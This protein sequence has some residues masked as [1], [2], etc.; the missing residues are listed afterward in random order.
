MKKIYSEEPSKNN[1]VLYFK[2]NLNFFNDN[3]PSSSLKLFK[4]IVNGCKE[5]RCLC[6]YNICYYNIMFLY[7]RI[8]WGC[9]CTFLFFNSCTETIFVYY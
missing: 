9:T 5:F 3:S 2:K 7:S 6:F 1:R 4:C 8:T